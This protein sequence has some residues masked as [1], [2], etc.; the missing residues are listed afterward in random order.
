MD[1]REGYTDEE[2]LRLIAEATGDVTDFEEF[3]ER[4]VLKL[5]MEKPF[6]AF[7]EQ[8]RDPDN[9][10]FP[11]FSGKIEIYSEHIAEMQNPQLPPVPKYIIATEGY[12]DVL[13]KEYP[14]QL[15]TTHHKPATHSSLEK[16]PWLAEAEPR[17]LWI[18]SRDAKMRTISHGDDVLVFNTRGTVMVKA[19]VTERIMPGVVNLGQGGW[20][21]IGEDGIDRG[22]CANTLVPDEHS[23]G[24]A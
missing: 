11:T 24:G 18:N 12:G 23:P 6:V 17:E 13:S 8:I 20:F 5:K 14:L 9:N 10:P 3:K 1:Y 16:V 19:K 7:R 2:W 4:G 21:D 22:A 15:M